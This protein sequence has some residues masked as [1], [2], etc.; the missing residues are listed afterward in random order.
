[1]KRIPH[2]YLHSIMT[3]IIKAYIEHI[4]L[5]YKQYL[6]IWNTYDLQSDKKNKTK[7]T[8]DIENLK[9]LYEITFNMLNTNTTSG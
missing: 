7:R 2:E 1:M 6:K 9:L 4:C 5:K 8:N 3:I